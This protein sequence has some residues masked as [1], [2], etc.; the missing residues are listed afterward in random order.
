LIVCFPPRPRGQALALQ[1][2]RELAVT[3]AKSQLGHFM[4]ISVVRALG[5]CSWAW[6]WRHECRRDYR[7]AG[8]DAR[9]RSDRRAI[10][11]F[12]RIR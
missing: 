4:G 1:L 11:A 8:R 9:D 3:G 2:A 7:R 5:P 12:G 10:V 6:W